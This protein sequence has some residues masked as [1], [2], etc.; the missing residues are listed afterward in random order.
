MSM[1][2]YTLE[3]SEDTEGN[4]LVAELYD[5][6]GL[7]EATERISYD[8][9]ALSPDSEEREAPERTRQTTADVTALDIQLTR[10]EGA[11]EV[12]VLGDR[13]ELIA[14]RITDEEWGLARSD[15]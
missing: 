14:E 13:E 8:D 4:E 10:T 11:F 15:A 5:I 6:D 1:E 3:L 7:I 12:R 9:F 2:T